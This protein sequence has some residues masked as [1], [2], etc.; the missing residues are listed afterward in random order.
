MKIKKSVNLMTIKEIKAKFL[1]NQIL[2]MIVEFTNAAEKIEAKIRHSNNQFFAEVQT[3][4]L[5]MEI[6]KI[7]K[8][9]SIVN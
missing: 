2:D 8:L 9:E 6:S 1:T 3:S 5:N 7:R 4:L